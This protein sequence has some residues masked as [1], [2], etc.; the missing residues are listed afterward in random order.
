[1][2]NNFISD[3]FC[4]FVVS[5]F[6][7]DPFNT[8]VVAVYLYSYQVYPYIHINSITTVGACKYTHAY[9]HV[10]ACMHT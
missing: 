2:V 9:I 1:M 7:V 6:N 5:S 10:H 8:L 4:G 3:Y